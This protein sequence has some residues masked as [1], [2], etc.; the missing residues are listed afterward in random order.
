MAHVV[1]PLDAPSTYRD[2]RS[3]IDA[4]SRA[5]ALSHTSTLYVGNLSF[6]TTE[7][8]M[9]EVFSRVADR[10]G[11]G[12]VRRIIMGLDRNQKTPCGFAFVEYYT[13]TEAV[14]CMRY[15]SGTKLDER[16]IRCDLDPG[17]TDG[18]QYGRGQSGG[19]VRDEYR[20]DFD[21]GRGGWGHNRLR[22]EEE[23]KRQ[24][25][26]ERERARRA[27]ETY[28]DD[29]VGGAIRIVPA[30]AEGLYDEQEGAAR[31]GLLMEGGESRKRGREDDDGDDDRGKSRRFEE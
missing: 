29:H 11:G 23:R 17:Y 7:E 9:Y 20:Q 27:G 18:R 28:R 4:L 15:I 25:E 2:G 16:V 22:E 12:G 13:H 21:A 10:S 3:G 30:G 31:D 14:D 8:Q 24:E 1:A 26:Q 5:Q 19:Q 6:Y